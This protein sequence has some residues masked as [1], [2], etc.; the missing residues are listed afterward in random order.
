MALPVEDA[1]RLVRLLGGAPKDA[2][3]VLDLRQ[4]TRRFLAARELRV[5]VGMAEGALDFE[6]GLAADERL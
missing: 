3:P 2:E 4:T 5:G 6:V 1:L